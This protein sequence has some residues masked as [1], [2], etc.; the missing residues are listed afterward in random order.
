MTCIMFHKHSMAKD[1]HVQIKLCKDF[2]M[3]HACGVTNLR[4]CEGCRDSVCPNAL[5][6]FTPF[7]RAPEPDE[8]YCPGCIGDIFGRAQ[9]LLANPIQPSAA[10]SAEPPANS[11]ASPS[12]AT[13]ASPI[14]PGSPI[15]NTGGTLAPLS[16]EGRETT[17]FGS[18]SSAEDQALA[19]ACQDQ[20]SLKTDDNDISWDDSLAEKRRKTTPPQDDLELPSAPTGPATEVQCDPNKIDVDLDDDVDPPEIKAELEKTEAQQEAENA[21][22]ADVE[23]DPAAKQ[24]GDDNMAVDEPNDPANSATGPL[25]IT[26]GPRKP[27][28]PKKFAIM[29]K[30]WSDIMLSLIHI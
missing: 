20:F 16:P 9:A 29:W 5:R 22:S 6:P 25:R 17:S 23:M 12:E 30:E 28:P 10:A 13:F 8:L 11:T 2:G 7:K 1:S 3:T 19:Q 26:F 15:A 21:N 4:Q 14:E 18:A 24:E 27:R